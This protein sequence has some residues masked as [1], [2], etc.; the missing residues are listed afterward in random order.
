M[1]MEVES[2]I[3][4]DEPRSALHYLIY[5]QQINEISTQLIDFSTPKNVLIFDLGGGTL[6]VSLHKVQANYDNMD[7]NVED[8]AISRYTRIGG[9]NFDESIA[10][11]FQEDFEAKYHVKITIRRIISAIQSR[12]SC[13]SRLRL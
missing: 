9:D 2:N 4:L 11:F 10:H 8:Y 3:L 13:S 6:D 7:L 12:A 1:P 5:Q